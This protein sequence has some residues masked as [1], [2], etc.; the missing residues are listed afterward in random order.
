MAQTDARKMAANQAVHLEVRAG[1]RP[2]ANTIPCAS[3]GHVFDGKRRHE[4]HH[5]LGYER[6][7]WFSAIVLCAVCHYRAHHPRATHCKRGHEFTKANT[8]IRKNGTRWCK[9]CNR[10]RLKKK[11]TA[12]WWRARKARKAAQHDG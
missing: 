2:H 7:H 3:C 6:E 9:Q 12:A 4:W 11:R 10:D 8:Q 1:I 5:N